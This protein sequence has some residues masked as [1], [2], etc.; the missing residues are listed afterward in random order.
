MNLKE[1]ITEHFPYG[2]DEKKYDDTVLVLRQLSTQ[3]HK[4][5]EEENYSEA[6]NK[7][8]EAH[9]KFVSACLAPY[10]FQRGKKTVIVKY[11][12]TKAVY[13]EDSGKDII[14]LA[15]MT[16]QMLIT[17]Y[18]FY[19]RNAY[20]GDR[21]N[22]TQEEDYFYKPFYYEFDIYPNIDDSHYESF[23]KKV[24][25][26]KWF[27][28]E[29]YKDEKCFEKSDEPSIAGKLCFSAS[30]YE[31]Q[32]VYMHLL[33]QITDPGLLK[34]ISEVDHKP[35]EKKFDKNVDPV[36]NGI[37]GTIQSG[38]EAVIYNVGQANC[39]YLYLNIDGIGQKRVFFDVGRPLD[40]VKDSSGK[41]CTNPDLYAGTEVSNNLVCIT[42][43]KPDA[44]IVSHWHY[45]HV[46]AAL[47]LGKYVYEETSSCMW[48]APVPNN[49]EVLRKYRRLI[50]FL[51]IRNKIKFVDNN[52]P[53]GVVKK[54]GDIELYQ[55]QGRKDKENESS[56]ILL[57]KHSLFAADSLYRFWPADLQKA[58]ISIDQMVA[59]HH[60][61]KIEDADKSVLSSAPSKSKNEVVVCVGKNDYYHPNTAH[62]AKLDN[63]FNKTVDF[64]TQKNTSRI[65][66]D[67]Y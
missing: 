36:L 49:D 25:N 21:R 6:T 12:D 50:N 32:D 54:E 46:Q 52:Y 30:K 60:G 56:L 29:L 64:Q 63:I 45:D 41:Y 14:S 4:A 55:G 62:M 38:S 44:I 3:Y 9:R 53:N 28:A 33:D 1:K 59:P 2:W 11:I 13:D 39:I 27:F 67:L 31:T 48:I 18:G 43:C 58:Y 16:P 37:T 65:R 17:D 61:S 57:V 5:L 26:G 40:Q 34:L 23:K 24:A 19:S 51:M 8:T 15:V 7:Y 47:S 35:E 20:W 66:F 42:G 10:K 22:Q